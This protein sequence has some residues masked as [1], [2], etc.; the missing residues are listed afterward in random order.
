MTNPSV[1]K[2]LVAIDGSDQALDAVRYIKNML[3]PEG[4]QVVLYHALRQIDQAF[5]DMGINPMG[6][7]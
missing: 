1:K 5:W 4:V 7:T 3:G 6:R 2:L